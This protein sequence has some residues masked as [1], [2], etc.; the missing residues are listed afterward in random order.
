MCSLQLSNDIDEEFAAEVWKLCLRL[1]TAFRP[2]THDLQV[3]AKTLTCSACLN[4]SHKAAAR[5]LKAAAGHVE[6]KRTFP[7]WKQRVLTTVLMLQESYLCSAGA[8][9]M[10]ADD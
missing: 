4:L 8:K 5:H 10:T 3:K 7:S 2:M 6:V 1:E 9:V